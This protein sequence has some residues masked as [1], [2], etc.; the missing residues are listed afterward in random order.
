MRC[1][2]VWQRSMRCTRPCLGRFICLL[3]VFL[4]PYISVRTT[5][6]AA[7][8]A[9]P[10]CRT[11]VSGRRQQQ[12]SSAGR[13]SESAA[14]LYLTA[15]CCCRQSPM[16]HAGRQHVRVHSCLHFVYCP[17]RNFSQVGLLILV[18]KWSLY[19]RPNIAACCCSSVLLFSGVLYAAVSSRRQHQYTVQQRGAILAVNGQQYEPACCL[20]LSAFAYRL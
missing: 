20:L 13:F 6:F 8:R 18:P 11:A 7:D 9:V 5:L 3:F 19:V 16:H 15:V 17:G 1:L 4:S 2:H 14:C 10:F 12:Y